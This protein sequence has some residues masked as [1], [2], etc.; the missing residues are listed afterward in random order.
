MAAAQWR[1]WRNISE[2]N[3]MKAAWRKRN[4]ISVMA[5]WHHGIKR[6]Q[7][8]A[9]NGGKRKKSKMAAIILMKM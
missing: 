6:N 9:K 7:S 8:M 3:R 1:Q 2:N 5:K 4:N